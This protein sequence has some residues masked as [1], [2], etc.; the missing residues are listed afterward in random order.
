MNTTKSLRPKTKT[1]AQIRAA[2]DDG[3]ILPTIKANGHASIHV[4]QSKVDSLERLLSSDK[5]DNSSFPTS[6]MADYYMSETLYA[7]AEQIE[8]WLA[9][10]T[11]TELQTLTT[12]F[13][14]DAEP[15]P[16]TSTGFTTDRT[17]KN[18]KE[19][20]AHDVN[21]VLRKDR[22]N[23]QGFTMV[24]AYP[25]VI[26]DTAEQTG[27]D[28]R[29]IL[30]QTPTYQTSTPLSKALLEHRCNP[31][32]DFEVKRFL[33]MNGK[34]EALRFS[35]PTDNPET[36]H[37]ITMTESALNLTTKRN[38]IKT[39]S[40]FTDLS[41]KSY[42]ESG[43]RTDVDLHDPIIWKAFST[44]YPKYA[45]AITDMQSVVDANT[46]KDA[47]TKSY[48]D[49][50]L[51][52][53]LLNYQQMGKHQNI[54][55]SYQ[56]GTTPRTN[57]LSMRIPIDPITNAPVN[58]PTATNKAHFVNIRENSIS[59]TTRQ[60]GE[61]VD[62]DFVSPKNGKKFAYMTDAD[63]WK[64]FEEKYPEHA[65]AVTDLQRCIQAQIPSAAKPAAEIAKYKPTQVSSIDRDA[66]KKQGIH[67]RPKT[68]TNGQSWFNIHIPVDKNDM[69]RV[70]PFQTTDTQHIVHVYPDKITSSTLQS[71]NFIESNLT[72]I[73]KR[74]Q[75]RTAGKTT[76]YLTSNQ[77]LW[78]EFAALYPDH[79]NAAQ[80]IQA[81]MMS[82]IHD[83]RV[84]Q[85]KAVSNN[86]DW[87]TPSDQQTYDTPNS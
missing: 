22:T 79:A 5:L 4:K 53:A 33:P 77:Q 6:A 71:G 85:A 66:Y 68:N 54:S 87:S 48:S 12:T 27:N 58:D 47:P 81:E 21:V 75:P 80:E 50:K 43:V 14:P 52:Q 34:P 26:S 45:T 15:A 82:Q 8:T 25:N 35:I 72:D 57:Q 84:A 7:N 42:G 74:I 63:V 56:Q 20:A 1:A 38:G 10:A 61:Y 70:V 83:K 23:T 78:D 29:D 3:R 30:R 11:N 67:V 17:T 49:D 9:D 69:T 2:I 18:I 37:V 32:S 41:V 40:N 46:S 60:N 13:D 51:R 16:N 86:I 64:K 59:I 62:S 24:T 73:Q 31:A 44:K 28:I 36:E 55:A 39:A 65:K 76:A 19:C